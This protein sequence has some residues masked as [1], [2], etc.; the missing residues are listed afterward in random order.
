MRR[1]SRNSP[2]AAA[3]IVALVAIADGHVSQAEAQALDRLRIA[4]R[5]GLDGPAWHEVLTVLCQDLLLS[6][7]LTWAEVC[8][9]DAATVRQL[10]DDVTDPALQR[11]VL[12][13]GVSLA[14]ADGHVADDEGR[15]LAA[16][17]EQWGLR[18]ELVD[19]AP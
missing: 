1:Y 11:Q 18:D 16:A 19:L 3:R 2:Q 17:V 14:S 10:L 6:M 4:E 8:R 9:I 7:D 15:L 13:L 5:L 12:A